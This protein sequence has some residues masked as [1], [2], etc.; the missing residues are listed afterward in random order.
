[1]TRLSAA[2][3]RNLRLYDE[4][5]GKRDAKP[6]TLPLVQW[7]AKL[8][9]NG[10]WIQI[11]EVLPSLNVWS[12]WHW[13]LYQ[14]KIKE[15]SEAIGSLKLAFKLPKLEM[16]RVEVVYY[17][18]TNRRRDTDNY[19]PKLLLDALR[20]GG[21]IAEDNS[22]VLELAPPRFELDRERQRSEIFIYAVEG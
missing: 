18:S 8:L 17:F 7:D 15:L 3:L 19:T 6:A 1:M 10:I 9:P 11:P 20:Y 13:K 12:K 14:D 4:K 5:K 2:V 22:Q 16:A 21:I